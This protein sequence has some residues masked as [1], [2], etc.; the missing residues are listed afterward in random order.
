M[1]GKTYRPNTTQIPNEILDF[2][3]ADLSE[4]EL[5]VLLYI[6]RR[7][8]GFQKDGDHISL[9]QLVSGITRQS[10]MVLDV[11][12]GMSKPA[13]V[14][15]VKGL[16]ARG[17]ITVRRDESEANGKKTHETSHYSLNLDFAD[18]GAVASAGGRN[19]LQPPLQAPGNVEQPPPAQGGNVRQPPLVTLGS[20]GVVTQRDLQN[21]DQN[22]D[23]KDETGVA[24]SVDLA[25][26][27]RR[28]LRLAKPPQRARLI[29]QVRAAMQ[30][31]GLTPEGNPAGYEAR[32][33]AAAQ[34][35]GG[36]KRAG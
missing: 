12:T 36:R 29:A 5:K 19:N 24:P 18:S 27:E 2:L 33:M 30:R 9:R 22:K 17:L 21:L 10:G 23:P 14:R 13:V 1:S 34:D 7:T 8:L 6:V 35:A 3:M 11:G 31:E 25:E 26:R 4:A 20:T 28:G 15:G 32:L 16:E